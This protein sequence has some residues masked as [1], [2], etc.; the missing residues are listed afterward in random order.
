MQNNK[1]KILVVDDDKSILKLLEINLKMEGYGVFTAMD[2]LEGIEKF[3]KNKP[4]LIIVDLKMPVMDGYHFCWN[5]LYEDGLYVSPTPKIII[6]SARD[7][8]LDKGISK[9]IGVSEYITKPFEMETV[10]NKVK[11]LLESETMENKKKIIIIDDD[12]NIAELI[13][14]NL[15]SDKYEYITAF[16]GIEGSKIIETKKPDLIIL[17]LLMPGKT[18][19]EVCSD[20]KT[21]PATQKIPV[22]LLTKKRE[23]KDRYIGT[24]FLKADEYIPKPFVMDEL[25]K[26]IEKLIG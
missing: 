26:K 23:H 1:Q 15:P 4:D 14:A 6:L 13:M 22:I 19:Y 25:L 18:G 8:K 5:V 7:E 12:P 24:V 2:G 20:I 16:D 3:R 9:K 11:S 10:I 21:N 17:D